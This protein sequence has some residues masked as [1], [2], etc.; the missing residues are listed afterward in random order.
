V[1]EATPGPIGPEPGET[2]VTRPARPRWQLG[3]RGMMLF[4]AACAVWL[5]FRFNHQEN[6]SLEA[7]IATMRP[8]ARELVVEDEAKAA[9]VKLEE[10]W[11]D[12]NRWDVYLPSGQYRLCLATRAI[13]GQGLAPVAASRPLP[14][15][16]HSIEVALHKEKAGWRVDA[17]WDEANSVTVEEPLDWNPDKGSSTVGGYSESTTVPA[18]EPIVLHRC[19]FMRPQPNGSATST[20][21][22]TEGILIWIEPAAGPTERR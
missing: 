9:V 14:P 13:G 11:M 12:D 2:P 8:L 4:T 19:S 10:L 15:G 5:A 17:T 22:P 20:N 1:T 16:R 3:L 6:A 18:N 7:R 21:G